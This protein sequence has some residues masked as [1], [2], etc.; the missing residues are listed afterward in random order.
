MPT[1]STRERTYH[2]R[3]I[4]GTV[5]LE[6]NL[7]GVMRSLS[8]MCI[9]VGQGIAIALECLSTEDASPGRSLYPPRAWHMLMNKAI[10]SRSGFALSSGADG[11]IRDR[12][13]KGAGCD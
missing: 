9:G 3:R 7:S 2:L 6:L 8:T 5:A 10:Q 12:S 11:L 4:T 13:W 1:G